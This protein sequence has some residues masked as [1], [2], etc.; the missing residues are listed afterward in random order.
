MTNRHA[1]SLP[2]R[3]FLLAALL[4]VAG[5]AGAA[6]SPNCKYVNIGELPLRFSG[7]SFQPV[8]EGGINGG[9]ATM[10]VDT[11]AERSALTMTAVDRLEL[12]PQFTG[13]HAEGIGGTSRIY[14]ARVNNFTV[15]PTQSKSMSLDVLGDM[16]RPPDF[17]AIVGA[18]FLFQ[19]DIEIALAEKKVRFFRPLDCNKDSFLAYWAN[20]AVVVPLETSFGNSKNRLITV[21]LNGVEVDAL[22]D[23]G[24]AR[25]TVFESAAR[26]AGVA[27]D[28]ASSRSAGSAVGV[29]SDVVAQ[30]SAVFANF[31]I[32]GETIRDAEMLISRDTN[33]GGF[34]PGML[35][36]ADFLR[37]HRLLFAMSQRKLY[38]TYL[39]GEVFERDAKG[40]PAWLQQEADS[41][42]PDALLALAARYST[43][44]Q[45]P[46][47]AAR[48][49]ALL[50]QAAGK[51]HLPAMQALADLQ[52]R[53]RRYAEAAALYQ[54]IIAARPERRRDWMMLYLARLNGGEGADAAAELRQRLAADKKHAWPAPVGDF[55][56]GSIDAN[57]LL[58]AARAD[59]DLAKPRTCDAKAYM[60]QL[61]AAKGDV[62]L[63]RSMSAERTI[64]CR[65]GARPEGK[66]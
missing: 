37:A 36:G 62:T 32:G 9:P 27:P 22:I 17:D 41:G 1:S 54:R 26:K 50:E 14:S 31:S 46:R 44:R 42:N 35:L 25:T 6:D 39:G 33:G 66:Q 53:N 48:S 64:E 58:A 55:F 65:P 2:L 63:A 21:K 40:I 47:D 29:G 60:I 19:A 34:Q 8:I 10:L 23:T 43:G 15:W 52:M 4:G 11:G 30:R 13:R 38:I 56:T 24:A 28:H 20:D 49:V 59:S 45:V 61:A 16:A 12:A 5:L 18:D 3:F 51:N 57:G 7:P